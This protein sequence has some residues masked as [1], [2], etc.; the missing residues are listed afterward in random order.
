MRVYLSNRQQDEEHSYSNGDFNGSTVCA[1]TI[2]RRSDEAD[3][4]ASACASKGRCNAWARFS[5][6]DS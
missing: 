1:V 4:V 3:Y 2:W 5:D 6:A